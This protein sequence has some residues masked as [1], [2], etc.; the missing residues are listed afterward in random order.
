M[1]TNHKIHKTDYMIMIIG[2]LI[3]PLFSLYLSSK[4]SLFYENLTYVGNLPKN[5]I[6]FIIW[7]ICQSLYYFCCFHLL[8]KKMH[9]QKRREYILSLLFTFISIIAFL[10]PYTNHSS[11]LCSQ[12]HVYGSMLSCIATYLILIGVINDSA[13]Y[14]FAYFDHCRKLLAAILSAFAFCILLFGDIS[15]LSELILLDGLNILF[16]YM[17]LK[18]NERI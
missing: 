6:I 9:I 5:R 11:D 16:V 18:A 17:L 7:G 12:L 8:Y 4:A 3:L 14:D 10:V 1:K 15:T 2:V 13:S